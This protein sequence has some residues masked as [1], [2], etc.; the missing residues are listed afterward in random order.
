MKTLYDRALLHARLFGLDLER[1]ARSLQGLPAYLRDLHVLRAR[2]AA[3]FPI[4]RLYPCLGDRFEAAGTVSEHYFYQDWWVAR[5][6]FERAPRRHVDVGSR[7]DGFVAQVAAFREIEVFDLRP[8]AL[9]VP[10][11]HFRQ[12]DLMQR[13]PELDGCC[14]SLS[15]LHAI[16][17]FGLGRYGDAIDPRGHERGLAG[18]HHLLEPGGRLY[19]SVP[20]GE[21]RIEYNAHRVFSVRTLLELVAGRFRVEAFSFV[22]DANRFHPEVGLAPSE[23]E[24]D[25]GCHYGCGILELVKL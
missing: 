19:L 5:R 2:E 6:I 17:H 24:R 11:I 12:V 23:V 21:Q 15:S 8:L 22:D 9:D 16:E 13:H 14:D 10:T 4:R 25:F 20:I 1:T 18:L 7:I 3:G